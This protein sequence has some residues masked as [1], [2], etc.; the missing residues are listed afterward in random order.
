C[1]RYSGAA[2]YGRAYFDFW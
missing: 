1:A 2:A